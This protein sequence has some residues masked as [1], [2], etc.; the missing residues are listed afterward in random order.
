MKKD[1]TVLITGASGGIGASLAHLFAQ[2]GYRLILVA[3]SEQKMQALAQ[4]LYDLHQTSCIIIAQDLSLPHAAHT[5]YNKVAQEDLNVDIL[6]NNAGF[7]KLG[8]FL[9][10]SPSTIEEMAQLNV[11][12]LTLLTSLFLPGM[13]ERKRGKILNVASTAAFQSLPY[14]AVYAATK[15]YVLSFTEALHAEL[16]HTPIAVTALCPGP[17]HTDFAKRADAEHTTLF[18]KSMSPD[19]VARQAYAALMKNKMTCITGTANRFIVFLEKLIPSRRLLSLLSTKAM[20]WAGK[21]Q[22]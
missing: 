5:L 16:K 4:Q 21:K 6:V 14:F 12:T 1:A 17:T 22:A 7:G 11:A 19:D 18:F 3:R 2:E 15:A 20:K 10:Q 13:L 9:E 8:C